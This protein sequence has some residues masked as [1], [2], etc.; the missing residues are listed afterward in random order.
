[1]LR[2][3]FSLQTQQA[4]YSI[5][6]DKEAVIELYAAESGD[7]KEDSYLGYFKRSWVSKKDGAYTGTGKRYQRNYFPLAYS[8]ADEYGRPSV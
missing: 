6:V 2:F 7:D 1:M 8:V 4:G 3:P 5:T